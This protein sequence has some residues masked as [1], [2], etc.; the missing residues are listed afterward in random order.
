M[1]DLLH[2]LPRARAREAEALEWLL[3][4]LQWRHVSK[5]AHLHAL[6]VVKAARAAR[7]WRM[8]LESIQEEK[9]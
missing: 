1:T 9:K 3:L 6:A 2:D 8:K 5:G 4:A 7:A